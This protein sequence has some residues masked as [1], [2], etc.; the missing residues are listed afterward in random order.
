MKKTNI[1]F[2]CLGNICRSPSAETIMKQLVQTKGLQNK[3]YIDSAGIIGFHAGEPADARMRAHA[4]K[5][6]YSIT[7]ISRQFNP[8]TDF[9]DFDLI[10]GMDKKNIQDLQSLT[11]EEEFLQKIYLMTKFNKIFKEEGVP[12]PYYGGYEGFEYVLDLLEDA[13]SGLLSELEEF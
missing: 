6:D 1:L 2:V 12:D 13:C 5:R 4:K 7:S 11:I 10:I 8:I 3:Y 9:K